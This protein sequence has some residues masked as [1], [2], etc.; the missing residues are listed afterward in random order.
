MTCYPHRDSGSA[1]IERVKD[2]LL[3]IDAEDRDTWLRCLMA[4]KSEFGEVGYSIGDDWS[5]SASNYNEHDFLKTWDSLQG[6]G[7]G[8]RTLL[9]LARVNGWIDDKTYPTLTPEDVESRKVKRKKE[10]TEITAKRTQAKAKAAKWASA[11]WRQAETPANHPYLTKKQV[12]PTDTLKEIHT[13]QLAKILGYSVTAKGVPLSGRVLVAPIQR[14]GEST[15]CS[16]EFIDEEGRKSRLPGFG[17]STGGYWSTE[18]IEKEPPLILIGEGVATTAS[19]SQAINAPGIAALSSSNLPSIAR[20][21]RE[22]YPTSVIIV[23]ADIDKKTAQPDP[24]AVNAAKAV[25]GYLAV[26]EFGKDRTAGEKDFNDMIVKLG[27]DAVKACLYATLRRVSGGPDEPVVSGGDWPEPAE[28]T[29]SSDS[30][31]YP[32]DAIPSVVR[33]AINEVVR[34]VMCPTPLAVSCA[35]GAMALACQGQYDVQRKPGL[36]GPT[37]LF[38]LTIAESGERKSECERLLMERIR[39]YEDGQK[40]LAESHVKAHRAEQEAWEAVKAGLLEN[41]KRGA[42]ACKDTSP[43]AEQLRIHAQEEP[44]PLLIPG[45]FLEEP[46][47]Q[48]LVYS[49]GNKWPTTGIFSDEAGVVFGGYAMKAD[50]AMNTFASWNKLWSGSSLS[51][52]RRGESYAARNCRLSMHLLTQES[53]FREFIAKN[54]GLVRGTGLM[55]RYLVSWPDSTMGTRFLDPA[56]VGDTPPKPN[57]EKFNL[58]ILDILERPLPCAEAGGLNPQTIPLSGSAMAVWC[59]FF[60]QIEKELAKGGE[61]ASV[62]D[63]ASKTAENAARIAAL[64]YVMTTPF[65]GVLEIDAD[66]MGAGCMLAGWH[67]TESQ[68][69]L[70]GADMPKERNTAIILDE[71]LIRRCLKEGEQEVPRSTILQYGP[72]PLRSK[73]AL[74]KSLS[75][76]KDMGRARAVVKN[77][78]IIIEINP[79]IF[80]MTP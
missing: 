67:L 68:R 61:L 54:R 65:G 26:P 27:A 19:A 4:I 48:A 13:H 43:I 24:Q 59:D 6:E 12:E 10:Q 32:L 36:K 16:M 76:L 20:A 77:N 30:A 37:S 63:V 38:L 15:M 23:L 64:F 50:N 28:L 80:R 46:T 8:I 41:I 55:A 42:K 71:W 72:N 45:L 49:L 1:T 74:D 3:H 73:V 69:F 11:I 18:C 51:N 60:N 58:R 56:T 25:N 79:A 47:T 29:A 5:R 78:K 75:E 22:S 40:Q 52:E 9:H 62:K 53:T 7:V 17:T 57:L 14:Q 35:L 70:A 44:P 66:S 39:T 33:G 34:E 31:A 2:A 21:I